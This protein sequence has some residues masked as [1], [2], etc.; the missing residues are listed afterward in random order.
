MT[1]CFCSK[2]HARNTMRTITKKKKTSHSLL[3][4]INQFELL[5]VNKEMYPAF[6]AFP[7]PRPHPYYFLGYMFLVP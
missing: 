1:L 4:I 2:I 5:C 6:I 3:H 7:F